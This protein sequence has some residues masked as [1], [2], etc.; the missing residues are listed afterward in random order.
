M[1]ALTTFPSQDE[2]K[3]W[4]QGQN[5][6]PVYKV[7]GHFH[8]PY[9]FSAFENISEVLDMA[10]QENVRVIGI[11][12][13]ITMDG[14]PEFYDQAQAHK[15][16]PLFNIEFMGL[17]KEEQAKGDRVNDPNNPG[18]TYFSGKGL[19]FPVKL[20]GPSAEKLSS[21]FQESLAQ[22][23]S[24]V[25]KLNQHLIAKEIDFSLPFE[26]IKKKYAKELVRERH[27][28]KALRIEVFAYAETDEERK[29]VLEQ[30]Y[31]G[32]EVK[33]NMHDT[34]ALDNE[35]RSNLLKAGGVAF[36]PEDPKAFLEI[37][38]VIRIIL[39]AGGIPCYPVLL[40]DARGNFTEF[41]KDWD[42]LH[43]RLSSLNVHCIELI[44][45]R[46]KYEIFKEFVQFFRQRDYV[47]TFGTEHNTPAMEP[48]T[49]GCRNDVPLDDELLQINYE[50]ATVVAAHQYL[51]AKGETGY[52]DQDGNPRK[53]LMHDFVQLGKA[54]IE[55]FVQA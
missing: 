32:K 5:T 36:V 21:V 34:A 28:A 44:P 41:E 4:Y 15:K 18:R 2:L 12:D 8:T 35:I 19:D 55:K 33:V 29:N 49:V 40:D 42:H 48:L 11:N 47:I 13:F 45:G 25:E 46:N 22:T 27:I 37:E 16:F 31:D 17:L 10:D 54:V 23:R 43:Q 39:D 20:T 7:N 24:M 51:R 9:S 26:D 38:E 30:I 6:R 3:R 50:G 52:V 53:D 1:N 14:Y